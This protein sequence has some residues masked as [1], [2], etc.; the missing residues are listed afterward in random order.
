MELFKVLRFG[1]ARDLEYKILLA[2]IVKMDS[3]KSYF[4]DVIHRLVKN[5]LRLFFFIYEMINKYLVHPS[6]KNSYINQYHKNTIVVMEKLSNINIF[7][8]LSYEQSIAIDDMINGFTALPIEITFIM[9]QLI[10]SDLLMQHFI[11][12]SYKIYYM[13][14]L[15][16]LNRSNKE[17]FKIIFSTYSYFIFLYIDD[18]FIE[19]KEV[20]IY[21]YGSY[22]SKAVKYKMVDQKLI[23]FI[24][25]MSLDKF[26]ES[27]ESIQPISIVHTNC[28]LSK[29]MSAHLK[30]SLK[31]I[32]YFKKDDL[33]YLLY[34]LKN[35][36]VEFYDIVLKAKLDM[37]LNLDFMLR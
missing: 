6:K 18:M 23:D 33:K 28:S 16:K 30:L 8:T 36:R 20:V 27:I 5:D 3:N 26:K 22:I 32:R 21:L 4:N 25:N 13:N 31:E 17:L 29:R 37:N 1:F 34:F 35:Y 7:D 15:K 24:I 9:N 12:I 11:N 2:I 19:D 14:Y 10:K